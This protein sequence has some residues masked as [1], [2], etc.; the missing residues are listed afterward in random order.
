LGEFE[1]Y[2]VE[3]KIPHCIYTEEKKESVIWQT[4]EASEAVV[5]CVC[6]TEGL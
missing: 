5:S 2:Q 6:Q 3:L 4:T 1:S